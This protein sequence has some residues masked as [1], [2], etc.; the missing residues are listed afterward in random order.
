MGFFKAVKEGI[1]EGLSSAA[2]DWIYKEGY[3][4]GL[5][6]N[7]RNMSLCKNKGQR[8]EMTY[9]QGMVETKD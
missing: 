1:N 5:N 8:S 2:T 4:D 7:H 3:Q 6:G 9:S